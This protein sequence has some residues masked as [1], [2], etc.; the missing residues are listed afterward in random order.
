MFR[1]RLIS[2]PAGGQ[3]Q[4]RPAGGTPVDSGGLVCG[5]GQ[6]NGAE[7]GVSGGLTPLLKSGVDDRS[8]GTL[9]F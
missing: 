4:T 8:A 5:E 9:V 7:V 6:R 2:G 1:L 3:S